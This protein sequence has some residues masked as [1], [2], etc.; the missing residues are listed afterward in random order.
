MLQT[1]N[2]GCHALYNMHGSTNLT[3]TYHQNLSFNVRDAKLLI[4][5]NA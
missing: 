2:C 5:T 4:K 1:N 3:M